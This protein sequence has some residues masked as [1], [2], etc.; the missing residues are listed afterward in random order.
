M[1]PREAITAALRGRGFRHGREV[2]HEAIAASSNG[3]R[4]RGAVVMA[5]GRMVKSGEVEK[6]AIEGWTCRGGGQVY[7]YRLREGA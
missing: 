1:T 6:R 3:K 4:P 2:M 7:A 5:L